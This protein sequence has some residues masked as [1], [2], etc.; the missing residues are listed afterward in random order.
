MKNRHIS[1]YPNKK[2][3]ILVATIL[4]LTTNAIRIRDDEDEAA[5]KAQISEEDA[6]YMFSQANLDGV[7]IMDLPDAPAK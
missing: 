5:K 7:K 4:A 1:T 6:M 3:L 2:K